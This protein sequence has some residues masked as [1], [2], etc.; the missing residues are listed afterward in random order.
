MHSF[1]GL[2]LAWYGRGKT[3]ALAVL[4][5]DRE[6]VELVQVFE[7]LGSD[8]EILKAIASSTLPDSA[9]AI[10]AP[11]VISNATGQRACE[12]EIGRRFG[13]ADASAHTS[14]LARFPNAR[15]VSI[16]NR[17]VAAG[18]RH[19][20]NPASDRRCRGRCLFE[21]YPHPVHVVLFD[22]H[23]IMKYKKGNMALRRAGLT[24]FRQAI[25]KHLGAAAPTLMAGALLHQVV[26]GQL[27]AL[28]GGALK[29]YEDTLDALLCAFIAAHY[30]AW[31]AERNE[32]IGTMAEGY[33]VTPSRTVG[34]LPWSFERTRT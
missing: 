4:L 12:T 17:L 27:E 19:Q 1:L 16:A 31:G 28:R 10:D 23:R 3:S 6:R 5:G 11:L 13:H 14:N 20:V 21:V 33:I 2:D 30:W 25:M 22:L 18:W 24:T 29:T 8:E 7:T 26:D 9:L 32:M 15:S 34:G